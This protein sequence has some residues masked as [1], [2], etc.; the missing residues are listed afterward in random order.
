VAELD[1]EFR[2]AEALEP[3]ARRRLLSGLTPTGI[4]RRLEEFGID[5]AELAA[6]LPARLNRISE[7]IETGGSRSTS[8][9]MKWTPCSPAPSA[10]E[11]VWRRACSRRR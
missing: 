8:E 6:E 7:S 2:F 4:L 11:T 1:P 3:Y 9:P 10:W 5:V